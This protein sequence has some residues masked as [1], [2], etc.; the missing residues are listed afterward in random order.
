MGSYGYRHPPVQVPDQPSPRRVF[1]C[2]G[3][4]DGPVSRAYLLQS[5]EGWLNIP[6]HRDTL[7]DALIERL[8]LA[9]DREEFL[10]V[11]HALQA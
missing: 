3:V 10:K 9:T 2:T 7:M 11:S 1:R 5:H 8:R 6:N 4:A